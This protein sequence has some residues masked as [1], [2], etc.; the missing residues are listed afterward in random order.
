MT[1]SPGTADPDSSLVTTI[2]GVGGDDPL[3]AGAVAPVDAGGVGRWAGGSAGA[4]IGKGSD[5]AGEAGG[6]G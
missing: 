4:G 2:T 6:R 3:A 1:T 5:D